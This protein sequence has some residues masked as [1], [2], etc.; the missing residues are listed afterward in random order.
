MA[1][2]VSFRLSRELSRS[3]TKLARE[4]GVPKSQL[5]REA[6]ESYLA[7]AEPPASPS[8]VRERLAPYVGMVTLDYGALASDPVARQIRDRNWRR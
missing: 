8:V 6:I 7:S 3:L 4:R 1:S 5:V 2:T